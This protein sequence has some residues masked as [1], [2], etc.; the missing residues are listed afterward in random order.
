[1]HVND[2]QIVDHFKWVRSEKSHTLIIVSF[3]VVNRHTHTR[4]YKLII[5]TEKQV[6]NIGLG[7][8]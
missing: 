5:D 7:R 3:L 1:M 2:V 6:W 4:A 8:L